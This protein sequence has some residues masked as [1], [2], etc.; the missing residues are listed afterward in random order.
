MPSTIRLGDRVH[1]SALTLGVV[2]SVMA[3]ACGGGSSAP[4]ETSPQTT[5]AV[6]GGTT[7]AAPSVTAP[8]EGQS[9]TTTSEGVESEEPTSSECSLDAPA[10]CGGSATLV[11]DGETI[12]FDF[13]ACF[14]DADAAAAVG[15]DGVTFAALG[16]VADAGGIASVGASVNETT[17]A[18][19]VFYV[20][21][22]DPNTQWHGDNEG[23]LLKVEG[24]RVTYQGDL[25]EVVD[26]S[27]TG[28]KVDG[29]LDATC[30]P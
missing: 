25:L 29:S 15:S 2:A 18:N 5:A 17:F 1:R 22:G 10:S 24:N 14:F 7:S 23:D 27:V 19:E 16:Q 21:G 4:N 6:G 12:E 30:G 9:T 8:A 26:G 13:F 11:F 3:S 20:P 28:A